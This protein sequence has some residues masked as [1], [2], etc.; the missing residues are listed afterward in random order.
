MN[1]DPL[2]TQL[3]V[4]DAIVES[5]RRVGRSLHQPIRYGRVMKADR[6]WENGAAMTYGSVVHEGDRFRMW[7]QTAGRVL[8]GERTVVCYAESANGLDWEK[9]SLGLH[10]FKGSCDNNIVVVPPNGLQLNSPNVLFDVDDSGRPYKLTCFMKRSR[11]NPKEGGIW[12]AFSNDGIEW[13]WNEGPVISRTGDCNTIMSDPLGEYPYVAYVRSRRDIEIARRRVVSRSVSSDFIN[14]SEPEL[15]FGPDRDDG[16]D[17]EAYRMPVFVYGQTYLGFPAMLHTEIDRIDVQLASSRDGHTWERQV[18]RTPF[19]PRGESPAW[20]HAW[21]G[22]STNPPIQVHGSLY[23]FHEGREAAHGEPIPA[24][25]RSG[26]GLAVL[27][28]DGFVSLDAGPVEGEVVTRSFTWSGG[29]LV[30]NVDT[31]AGIGPVNRGMGYVNIEIL[32]HEGDVISGYETHLCRGLRDEFKRGNPNQVVR[33][34]SD[35]SLAALQGRRIAI[36]F[37]MRQARLYAF[38]SSLGVPGP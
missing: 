29:D 17:V 21:V 16:Y 4:D 5:T 28:Q 10:S 32:D 14:W 8:P 22:L 7:Y 33:W 30:V 31:N 26:V 27:R 1:I 38:R 18:D 12:V 3:F 6:P 36:R 20:D 24:L 23:L 19:L 13:V 25:R 35:V 37:T 15:T 2:R 11:S 34:D 9:P